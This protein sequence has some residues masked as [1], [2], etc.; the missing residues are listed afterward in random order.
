MPRITA[1]L[2][3]DLY[4]KLQQIAKNNNDS[5]SNTM[6]R[7][8]EIG[9]LVNEKEYTNNEVSSNATIENHCHKLIIETHGLLRIIARQKHHIHDETFANLR[10]VTLKMFKQKTE[11]SDGET[12]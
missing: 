8:T 9:L 12:P 5:L 11:V 7:L 10:V 1:S 3:D 6:T 4:L 2:T